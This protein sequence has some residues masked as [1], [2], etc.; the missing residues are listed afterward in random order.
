MKKFGWKFLIIGI[1]LLASLWSLYPSYRYYFEIKPHQKKYSEEEIL[2]VRKRSLNLGLDLQGGMYMLLELDTKKLKKGTV[3]DALNQAI[4]IIRNRIDQWG[5]YEPSIQ[6]AGSRRIL[7]QLPGVMERERARRLI[8]KTALLE[9]RLVAPPELLTKTIDKIDEVISKENADTLNF[10]NM[11]SYI[12]NDVVVFEEDIDEVEKIL[13]DTA[14]QK[15]IPAGYTFMFGR[16]E[17]TKDGR[18]YRRLYLLE[19]RVELT[20]AYIK[21]AYHTIGRG[22]YLNQP[23]VAL[24]FDRRGTRIFARITTR[25]VNRRL[26]IVLDSVVQSA[27][28]IIEPIRFGRAQITGIPTLDEAKDL[29][30]ILKAGALPAPLKI[31]E[32]RSVGPLLGLDSIRRGLRAIIIGFLSV[33]IFMIIYYNVS[34]LIASFAL[35]F[36]LILVLG[37][38]TAFRATLTLPG[39]AGL[40]LTIGMAI[41]AN[42][43]IFERIREE[44]AL[45]KGIRMSI[46]SGFKRAIITILDANLT[47]LIA[48]LVLFKFGTGPVRGFAT[49]LGL[50]IVCSFFTAVFVVKT[51]MDYIFVEKEAIALKL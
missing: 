5:V 14:V 4:E 27:P 40:I 49:V 38:L 2:K 50:G 29:A 47:T 19:K 3:K 17:E 6:K 33:M 39:M 22:Q 9:F 28:V 25:N 21:N 31:V 41:D 11:I 16:L 34:G 12:G 10:T 36:N 44:L 18:R 46:D 42:V 37:L 43:L 23:I 7:V 45:G 20:G 24:E 13:K 51:I 30:I 35:I 32:E 26:A 1:V 48:A 15:V 8:G